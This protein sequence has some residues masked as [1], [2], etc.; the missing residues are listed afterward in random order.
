MGPMIASQQ[1]YTVAPSPSIFP[2]PKLFFH[3]WATG[4]AD[5][6]KLY[7]ELYGG[8]KV[9]RGG[10][11]A[12]A[13]ATGFILDRRSCFWQSQKTWGGVIFDG[14]GGESPPFPLCPI[15]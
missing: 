13:Y 5:F 6:C 4:L 15:S 1:S 9:D 3:H 8:A 14:I 7:G 10:L 11:Q 12:Y 2:C